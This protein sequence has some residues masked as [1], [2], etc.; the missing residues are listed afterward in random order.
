MGSFGRDK[1]PCQENADSFQSY[2][3]RGTKHVAVEETMLPIFEFIDENVIGGK[4]S[5]EGPYGQRRVIYC[6]Y[7]ASGKPLRFIERYIREFVYPFYANTHTTTSVTSRQTT[8]F[9]QEAREIIKKCVNAGQ[10]D[11][12]VFTGSGATGAIHK[13]IHALQLTGKVVDKTVVFVGPFEHHSNILPWKETGAKIIRIHDN[14]QGTVNMKMLE[15][16]LRKYRLAEYNMYVAFSAASNVTGIQTDTVAVAELCHKYGALS[17]WDYASAGPYLKIDMNPT[18]TGYKDAVF[19]SPHKFVGGPGTP[20]LLIAKKRLFRNPVPGGCGGGTVLFVTRDTHLYLKD[21]EE[22]EEGGTP[23]I[24]ESVRAGMVFQLKESVGTKTIEDREE[25]LCR[26]AFQVWGKN[27]KITILGNE[28]ARRLPIFSLLIHHPDSGKILH[29]NFVSVLLNDLYGIQAR[30]GCACAGPYAQDLLGIN[31][32]IAKKF[33][34]FLESHENEDV[35]LSCREPLEIMKPGFA[36]VNLPYFMDDETVHFVLEAVDMIATHGWKLLPQ[37]R[38]D[39]HT[40]AWENRYFS[41]DKAKPPFSLHDV[42]YDE[43]G[44]VMKNT[45]KPLE[46]DVRLEDIAQA[47]SK[48]LK[49]AVE[50][51]KEINTL[52][53]ERVEFKDDKNQLIWFLQPQEAQ[54]YLAAETLKHK[55]NT[56]VRTRL[57]FKPRKS[58]RAARRWPEIKEIQEYLKKLKELE[59]GEEDIPQL[60]TV[61][62]NTTA[63]NKKIDG[64]HR[65]IIPREVWKPQ[66]KSEE[67]IAIGKKR[68]KV[69]CI[70]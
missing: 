69:C 21:I 45:G 51:N 46:L 18:L 42:T 32:T 27:P 60:P 1:V 20:G 29:H 7:T 17:F 43:I 14:D 11:V 19:L 8:R 61:N 50:L 9:R 41:A 67:L 12:V 62:N 68:S 10:D 39:P 52:D 55:P 40:G 47:A 56:F 2:E 23:A 28:K 5:F 35:E 63:M 13:L 64:D 70:Q 54:F 66:G 44:V 57:P 31:E 3:D 58:S 34:W 53:D 38:F 6:D 24:V 33:T 4:T 36:R 26:N 22:R 15:A 48:I 37:Y 25:E 49:D 30:G 65:F 59:V 16:Q